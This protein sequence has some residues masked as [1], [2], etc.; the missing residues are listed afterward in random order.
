MS[1]ETI[2]IALS[3]ATLIVIAAT[4]IAAIVQLRHLRTSNQLTALLEILDQWNQPTLLAAY[5]HFNQNMPDKIDD[6]EYVKVLQTGG[7]MDRGAHPEFLVCDLWEQ[8]G[9]Y[10]KYGLIDET[11]LLDIVAAQVSNAW[12]RVWPAIEIIRRRT[13][14]ATFE[15]FEYL[16]VRAELFQRRTPNG[17]YPRNLPRMADLPRA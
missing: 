6:P 3:A 7:S 9:T 4:A 16:A 12:K 5:S 14:P 17:V 15:N 13:G 8:V 2:S 1:G 10:A 11:I